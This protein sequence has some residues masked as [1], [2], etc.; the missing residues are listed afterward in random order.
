MHDSHIP[1]KGKV[2]LTDQ[3]YLAMTQEKHRS[4]KVRLDRQFLSNLLESCK[5][6]HITITHIPAGVCDGQFT[7]VQ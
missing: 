4:N 6:N 2:T 3:D 1:K 5:I 7:A